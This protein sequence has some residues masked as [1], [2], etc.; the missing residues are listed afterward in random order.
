MAR[1]FFAGILIVLSAVFLLLSIAGIVAV[2]FYNEPATREVTRQLKQIDGELA[3]AEA[4]LV[5]SEKELQRALRIVDAAQSALEKLTQQSESAESLFDG[6]QGT[7]DDRLLPELK[8]TRGRIDAARVTLVNLQSILAGVSSF[9]PGVDLNVPDKLLTDLIASTRSLD[10]E[11]ANVQVLATQ[12][13]TFVSD[14][15]LL[16]GGDLSETRDSLK[17]F[18]SAIQDYEK[19]VADWRKQ[20]QQLLAGAPRWIDQASIGLTVF[21]SWF[22]L[23]QLGL[24]LH[25]LNFHRGG[26]PFLALRR[27][28]RRNPLLKNA[29]DL[30]LEE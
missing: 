5:S 24:L 10:T 2:W 20:D 27:E 4:T 22:G 25:G 21:L 26:D 11:I 17:N 3:Q 6:I 7:L 8:R 12:A 9:V 23:S 16:L 28:K 1:K 18:L 19:K 30:E 15:S 14:T 13:S 29:R